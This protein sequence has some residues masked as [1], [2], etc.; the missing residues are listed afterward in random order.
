MVHVLLDSRMRHGG[1]G[2]YA[3]TLLLGLA[4][5]DRIRVSVIGPEDSAAKPFT[6]W[7]LRSIT[8]IGSRLGCDVIHGLHFEAPRSTLPVVVTIQDLIPLEY[9]ASMPSPLRRAAFRRVVRASVERASSI[10]VPSEE[11]RE[12]VRRFFGHTDPIVI[13]LAVAPAFAPPTGAEIDAARRRFAAGRAYV[14]STS[15]PRAHKNT[16]A[17]A[18]LARRLEGVP[19]VVHGSPPVPGASNLGRIEDADLRSLLGG[20]EA[21]VLPSIMEGFGLPAVEAAACGTPVVCGPGTPAA[22]HLTSSASVVDVADPR[23]VAEAVRSLLDDGQRR[24]RLA[25]AAAREASELSPRR[26]ADATAR[27]Y[28]AAAS[29]AG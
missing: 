23:A 7:G 27:V 25:E 2:R 10:I 16:T 11:T 22:A 18:E 12:S 8:R 26:M 20:A 13:P 6:P 4:E 14:A 5:L 28:E 21:Y 15:H 19:L 3:E 24:S 1:V 9:P 29:G 17:L